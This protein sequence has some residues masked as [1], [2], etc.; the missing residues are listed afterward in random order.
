MVR[1]TSTPRPEG[2]GIKGVLVIEVMTFKVPDRA[3]KRIF[4]AG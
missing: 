2:R 4:A 3:T 1:V